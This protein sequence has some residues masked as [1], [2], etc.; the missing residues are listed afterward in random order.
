[1]SYVLNSYLLTYTLTLWH[2][3]HR[4]KFFA[5]AIILIEMRSCYGLWISEPN[6][7]VSMQ[8]M[9]ALLCLL[10]TIRC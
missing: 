9:S 1:M 7:D 8:L 4:L 5:A 10:A 2:G 3:L 6:A